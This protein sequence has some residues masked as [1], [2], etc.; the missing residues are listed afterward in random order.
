VQK[1]KNSS[2]GSIAIAAP[3]SKLNYRRPQLSQVPMCAI[4]S[5]YCSCCWVLVVVV[6][7]A[8]ICGERKDDAATFV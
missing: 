5:S 6:A 7:Y 3:P 4:F 1:K 2:R 8:A